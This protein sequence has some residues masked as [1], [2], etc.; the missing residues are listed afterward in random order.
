[1]NTKC[2]VFIATSVDGF[3]ARTDGELDWLTGGE[4]SEVDEDYG[5]QNFIDTVDALIMGR[6]TFDKVLTFEEWPYS[7]K[8]IVLTNRSLKIPEKLSEAV[9]IMSGSPQEI[10]DQFSNEGF[11]HFYIDGGKTIQ[12]F[13][14]AGLIQEIILTRIPVIIGSGIPLFGPV[15]NDIKLEHVSTR[16]FKNGFV[17]SKYNVIPDTIQRH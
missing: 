4:T 2:S 13:L 7:K 12:N 17:Q 15:G 11:H 14:K 6:N 10:V 1:M 5:Y 8:V 9:V 3:I 16:S